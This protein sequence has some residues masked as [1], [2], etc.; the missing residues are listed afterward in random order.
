MVLRLGRVR[1]AIGEVLVVVVAAVWH[2]VGIPVVNGEGVMDWGDMGCVHDPR[3][4]SIARGV[5]NI[6]VCV[7]RIA[8][9][10]RG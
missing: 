8:W 2:V 3:C 5:W 10:I 9:D 6:R 7:A 1:M 4:T